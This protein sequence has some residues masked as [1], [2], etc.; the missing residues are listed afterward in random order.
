ME[1]EDEEE[2]DDKTKVED[3]SLAPCNDPEPSH[4]APPPEPLP[5]L[6]D[7]GAPVAEPDDD[8]L[9]EIVVCRFTVTLVVV[10]GLGSRLNK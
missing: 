9:Y 10:L 5:M 1:E 7:E 3:P 4:P 2:E 6:P 8:A